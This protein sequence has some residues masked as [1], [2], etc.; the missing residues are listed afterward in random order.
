MRIITIDN[1]NYIYNPI[2]QMVFEKDKSYS[3]IY[4]HIGYIRFN[5]SNGRK[6]IQPIDNKSK[7]ALRIKIKQA[8]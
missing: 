1:Q 2:S 8:Y 4:Y 6:Y 5:A 7:P 3:L